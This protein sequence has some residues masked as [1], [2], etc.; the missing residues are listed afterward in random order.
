[1]SSDGVAGFTSDED[2]RKSAVGEL[3]RL[4][5]G[6]D[7]N[8]NLHVFTAGTPEITRMRRFRDWL[9]SHDDD[10]DYYAAAKR[11][12]A[13]R[14]W[15]HVQHYADSKAAVVQEIMARADAAAG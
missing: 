9:R 11:D 6:P 3:H 13:G 2:R 12:L 4:F 15:R 10:R 8:I 1:V 5:K 7:T 14:R